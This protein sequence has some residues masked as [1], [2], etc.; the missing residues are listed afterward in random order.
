MNDRKLGYAILF[1]L[2]LTFAVVAVYLVRTVV[3]P[4]EVR[5]VSFERIGNL[6]IEDAV[7]VRGTLSGVIENIKWTKNKILVAIKFRKPLAIHQGYSIINMDEGIMGDRMVLVDVGDTTAPLCGV[8]DTLRGTFNPGV[9]EALGYAWQMRDLVDTFVAVTGRWVHGTAVN[10]SLITRTRSA[11]TTVDS[12]SK[13]VA[14]AARQIEAGVTGQ[15]D[16]INAIVNQTSV[17]ARTFAAAA[18]E[19][20]AA[21]DAYEKKLSAIVAMLHATASNL[22]ATVENL[23]GPGTVLW[24]DD[25]ETIRKNLVFLQ[26]I[27]E[28]V[29]QR[30]LQFKSNIRLN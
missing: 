13:A 11:I 21:I 29:Q 6:R 2:V 5:I 4:H 16:S 12:L 30:L 25:V 27:I 7:R 20:M 8:S 1:L 24:S 10:N 9:S 17:L 19:Y 18:P 14:E 28:A 22:R 23:Q 26:T 3:Y 15:I